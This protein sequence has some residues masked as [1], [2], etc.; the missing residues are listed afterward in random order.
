[1]Q[2]E[3]GLL[4]HSPNRG[5]HMEIRAQSVLL[6]FCL[7]PILNFVNQNKEQLGKGEYLFLLS[8]FAIALS[9]CIAIYWLVRLL[10][11]LSKQPN[12]VAAIVGLLIMFFNYSVIYQ[13]IEDVFSSLGLLHGSSYFYL[14]VLLT[15]SLTAFLVCKNKVVV[16]AL[17]VAGLVVIFFPTMTLSYYF[18]TKTHFRLAHANHSGQF[19]KLKRSP[20]IYYILTD[21]YARQ[22][23]LLKLFNYDNSPFLSYLKDH[24]FYVADRAYSNYPETFISLPSSLW[25]DYPVTEKSP[26]FSDRNVFYSIIQG[27]NPV[28]TYLKAHGYSYLHMGVGRWAG[29][30][31]GGNEDL[32]LADNDELKLVFYGMTPIAY[33]RRKYAITTAASLEKNLDTIAQYRSFFLFAHIQPPHPPATFDKDCQPVLEKQNTPYWHESGKP[34]YLNDLRCTNQQLI[35]VIDKILSRDPQASIILHS[36]HGTAYSV[37]W[38]WAL[39][40]WP[41]EAFE[42]RFSNLM[43]LRLPEECRQMLYPSLSPVNIFRVTFACLE[44]TPPK[45]LP[46]VSY[47]STYEGSKQFGGVYKY[48]H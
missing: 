13:F 42:E 31:C 35:R 40:Q 30:K 28:V 11:G 48:E 9:V 24:G 41:R 45:T 5:G 21:G 47:I 12:T 26:K 20:N 8:F 39:D 46:D 37:N 17:L 22:D 34:A 7:W 36:D 1:V 14:F 38:D 44:G 18:L 32:C 43:A 25:M 27:N 33:F 23:Q 19:T 2:E 4:N 10:F 15:I 6:L 3:T 16:D 29:S